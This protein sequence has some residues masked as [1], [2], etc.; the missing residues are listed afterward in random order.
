MVQST[1]QRIQI[2]DQSSTLKVPGDWNTQDGKLMLYEGAV[3]YRKKFDFAAKDGIRVNGVAPGS[4]EF[5]G[6]S[7][8]KRKSD[9]PSLYNAIQGDSRTALGTLPWATDLKI[10]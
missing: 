8:E 6:G 10:N 4:I 5:P 9:N 2:F 3:W 1:G 7:W